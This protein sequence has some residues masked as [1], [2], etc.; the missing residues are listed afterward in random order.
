MATKIPVKAAS[1]RPVLAKFM[2]MG[3]LT[4]ATTGRGVSI[5]GGDD[6]A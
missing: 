2:G 3:G 6:K 4:F 5:A 1:S